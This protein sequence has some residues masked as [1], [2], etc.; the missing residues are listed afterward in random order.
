M[1]TAASGLGGVPEVLEKL[2]VR[3]KSLLAPGLD[4][5]LLVR[6]ESR[7]V[8]GFY[9]VDSA[10]YQGDTWATPWYA[11]LEMRPAV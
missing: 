11:I 10:R 8:T 4:P 3:A 5:G 9:R 2:R 7:D 1:V 6:L